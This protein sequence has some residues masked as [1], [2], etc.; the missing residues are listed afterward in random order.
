MVYTIVV[1]LY[2]KDDPTAISKLQFK[3]TEA[4]QVYSRDRETVGWHVMQDISDPRKFTIVER[5]ERE[6][7]QK[8]HLEN[9]YWKTFDPFVMPLLEKPMDLMRFEELDPTL[10]SHVAEESSADPSVGQM[11]AGA[12]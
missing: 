10:G 7:S 8:Y 1:H 11:Y 12:T 5:Y 2:A 6:S 9:P 3:L 4:S